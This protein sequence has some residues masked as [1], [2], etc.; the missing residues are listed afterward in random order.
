MGSESDI[1]SDDAASSSSV[2]SS[3]TGDEA[4]DVAAPDVFVG[5]VPT[6]RL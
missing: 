2:L 3:D 6:Y 1:G 4:L 5:E